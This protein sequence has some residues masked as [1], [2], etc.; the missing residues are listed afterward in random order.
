MTIIEFFD[1]TA[2]ENIASALFC[3]PER[4]ILVGDHHKQMERAI[5]IYRDVLNKNDI[6]T[7]LSYE[8]IEKNNLQNIEEA[9][10][11][12]VEEHEDLI[13]DLT[14]GEDLYLVAVGV[15]KERYPE[16]VQ[17][18]R[19][20]FRSETINDC[21]ADGKVCDQ[22]NFDISIEDNIAMYGGEIVT[23]PGRELYTYPWT[24]DAEFD[25][26]IDAMWSVCRKNP[27]LWNAHITVLGEICK[28]L[29]MQDTLCVSFDKELA[30][31]MLAE[32]DF[33]FVF[34]TW[35][36]FELQNLGLIRSLVV[37][38]TISFA[39]KNEQVKRVLTVAGQI[40]E[41]VVAKALRSLTDKYGAP[42]YHD[43]KVGVVIDWENLDEDEYYRTVNEIDVMAMK[44]AIPI[45]ISCKNGYFDVNELYKLNT[46]ATRFGNKYAKKVLVA[47]ELEKLGE[48]A[49]YIRARMEDMNIRRIENVD[50][51]TES[52]LNK[53]LKTLWCT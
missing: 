20:N 38:D 11:A 17:C 22:K 34:V 14:G 47:A 19:F 12:I 39:F 4:V 43:V 23:D 50:E 8:V 51:L 15:I 45:F 3:K 52:E 41:L 30:A 1:K 36:M 7:E 10:A 5:E 29:D 37:S 16:K 9:L 21:D 6:T 25:A 18:Q 32:N 42:L 26:D 33:K 28:L 13:F 49:E 35:I 44:G 53:L 40:L 46:V 24:F 27:R 2:L 48:K 31:S